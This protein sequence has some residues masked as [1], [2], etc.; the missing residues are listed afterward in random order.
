[1]Q[2]LLKRIF[3]CVQCDHAVLK[4]FLVLEIELLFSGW[5]IGFMFLRMCLWST[6]VSVQLFDSQLIL[7]L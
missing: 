7:K 2:F 3:V 6:K 4:N 5:G 1:M